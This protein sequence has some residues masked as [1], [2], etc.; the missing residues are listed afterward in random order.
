MTSS[1]TS[2]EFIR[3]SVRLLPILQP[4]ACQRIKLCPCCAHFFLFFSLA[5]AS[6]WRTINYLYID[7]LALA[8]QEC[9]HSTQDA[10]SGALVGFD[11][12]KRF[13]GDSL[14]PRDKRVVGLN[15]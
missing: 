15:R 12:P 4:S 3:L 9:W 7:R 14:Q 6:N 1:T 2:I 5:N 8:L 11:G 10:V 13:R